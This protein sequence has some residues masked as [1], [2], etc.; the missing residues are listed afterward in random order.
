MALVRVGA[1]FRGGTGPKAI[2]K[3][4]KLMLRRI[5]WAEDPSG[6]SAGG[7][8]DGGDGGDDD[9]EDEDEDDEPAVAP[10]KLA[11]TATATAVGPAKLN[12]CLLVW[13]GSVKEP[14]FRR[15]QFKKCALEQDARDYL[16]RFRVEHYWDFAKNYVDKDY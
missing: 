14:A 5:K 3:Y 12:R 16:K 13:E 1:V 7:G 11:A 9:D 10:S 6:V 15:F 4:K 8:G 2:K